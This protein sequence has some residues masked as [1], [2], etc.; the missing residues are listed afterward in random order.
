MFKPWLS[1]VYISQLITCHEIAE[2]PSSRAAYRS[3]SSIQYVYQYI[4]IDM[5]YIIWYFTSD[6]IMYLWLY[7]CFPDTYIN[8][9]HRYSVQP[10]CTYLLCNVFVHNCDHSWRMYADLGG[11]LWFFF[12][13][14]RLSL[15]IRFELEIGCILWRHLLIRLI[16][17]SLR[18]IHRVF[19]YS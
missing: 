4:L 14:A 9:M 13:P 2:V 16:W 1:R 15:K 11:D 17:T 10:K 3:V 5:R 7:L 6:C 12:C 18:C 19:V 8:H